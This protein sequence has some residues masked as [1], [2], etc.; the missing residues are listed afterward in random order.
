MMDRAQMFEK[1]RNRPLRYD[2]ELVQ[3][4]VDV[5]DRVNEQKY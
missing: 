4:T 2:R 1:R 5:M 3:D